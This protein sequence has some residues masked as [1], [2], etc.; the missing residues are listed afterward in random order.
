VEARVPLVRMRIHE[1]TR[2]LL[3]GALCGAL[4]TTWAPRPAFGDVESCASSAE[5]AERSLKG[6]ALAQA[7]RELKG[8]LDA[9]CPGVLRETCADMLKKVDDATPTVVVSVRDGDG[10]DVAGALVTVDG[11]ASAD[12]ASGKAVELDPGQHVFEASAGERRARVEAV[13]KV[14]EKRR[15]LTLAF[16][17][18]APLAPLAPVAPAAEPPPRRP[19]W[20]GASAI[21]VGVVG[22]TSFAVFGA[23]ASGDVSRLEGDCKP[24]CDDSAIDAARTKALVADISLGVGLVAL[25]AGAY[26]LLTR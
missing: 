22:L 18:R 19:V 11:V 3:C 6:G 10:R 13:I 16:A 24:L 5:A 1:T 9:T 23:L 12:A 15:Q 17:P 8:C 7:R 4:L 14:G 20:V 26:L 21:G 25:A 2:R